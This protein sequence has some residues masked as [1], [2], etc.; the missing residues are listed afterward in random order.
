M[1]ERSALEGIAMLVSAKAS[2]DGYP[3]TRSELILQSE[4]L[5]ALL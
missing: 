2:R 3:L 1:R 4:Y 5:K